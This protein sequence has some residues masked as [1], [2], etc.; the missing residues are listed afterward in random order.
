MAR[1]EDEAMTQACPDCGEV[2]EDMGSQANLEAAHA[3]INS[4]YRKLVAGL[5]GSVFV[6]AIGLGMVHPGLGVFGLALFGMYFFYLNLRLC[7]NTRAQLEHALYTLHMTPVL[8]DSS[9]KSG[10]H[11]GSYL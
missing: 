4:K 3:N 1:S 11:H 5:L 2:H 6:A 7:E 8:P 10:D 9:K